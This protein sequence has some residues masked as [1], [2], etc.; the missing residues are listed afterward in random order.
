MNS[1][2]RGPG[3]VILIVVAVLHG[4]LQAEPVIPQQPPLRIDLAPGSLEQALAQLAGLTGLQILYAPDLLRGL[5]TPGLHGMMTPAEALR[6]LLVPADI[7]FEFTAGDAVALH[8]PTEPRT[9][10]VPAPAQA[11]TVTI[12]GDRN[13]RSSDRSA[14]S[15]TGVKL[16]ISSLLVPITS[17]SVTPASL[18]DQQP[19]RLEDALE[20]VSATETAPDGRSS[21]GF[22]IR[23]FPTYQ[24]YLD[25]VRVSP[26]LHRDG[27]RD[28]ANIDHIDVLKGPAS[29]LYGRSEPGGLVNVVTKQPLAT[30]LWSLEERTGSFGRLDTLLDAGGPLSVGQSLL[31]R[32]NA[33]WESS[34][35]FRDVPHSRRVF[36]APVLTWSPS[37]QTQTTAY[38]EYLDSHDPS[39]SGIPVIGQRIPT[40]PIGRSLEQGGEVHTTDLRIGARG[41][42]TFR[43]GWTLRHHVDVRWLHTPQA[44]QLALAADGLDPSQC[45]TS[46]CPVSRVLLTIPVSRGYTAYASGEMTRDFHTWGIGH[47][48]LAGVELFQTASYSHLELADDPSLTTDLF[49][50]T[51]TVIPESL[52][53][54]PDREIYRNARERWAAAYVQD[55]VSFGN[56]LYFLLGV[57]FDSAWASVGQMSSGSFSSGTIFTPFFLES[58]LQIQMVKHREGLVWRP[59]PWW[60]LYALHTENFGAAPGLYV[61]AN[62]Y[63]GLD[64]PPQSATEWEAGMKL[65]RLDGRFAAT[66]A[67]FD[68]M[69]EN[70]SSTILEPA[71]DSSWGTSF[72]TG[73]V[74]N[75]GLEVDLQGE[76]L[77][78]LQCLA[79]FAYLD[80]RISF[81]DGSSLSTSGDGSEFIGHTG[82]RF[83]GVPHDGG[84]A[85]CSYHFSNGFARGL[86]SGAGVIARGRRAGDN[87]NDYELPGFAKWSAFAAYGWRVGETRLSIQLNVDNLFN[88]RYFESINGTHT[89][90]PAFPRRWTA[91]LR[92]QF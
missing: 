19:T 28:L 26:D 65:E 24:Y 59:V 5:K 17:S 6:R 8:E 79:N 18:R 84:S 25:G 33:A 63:S 12:T 74:R 81:G 40:V 57:R 43:D 58:G 64:I 49:H 56:R 53:R 22:A 52:A 35:S 38:L 88:A 34:G 44:P 3:A 16:D 47:S 72:F 85:W 62:G 11:P 89:V 91:S 14:T 92:V 77:P 87:A 20:Y 60:S 76:I 39:D 7:P 13:S 70:V 1:P 45:T 51:S 67:A 10:A 73:T 30:S 86:K 9:H 82:S 78:H 48:L 36:V 83:F 66:L 4:T 23:G 69:K 46:H 54:Q 27:F 50:P 2:W 80:S 21:A 37:R 61:G 90:M 75:K 55:H 71:L 31:Y 41:S 15:L 42:Y 68:L 32:L 29:L